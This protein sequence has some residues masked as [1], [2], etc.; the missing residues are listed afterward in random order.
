MLGRFEQHRGAILGNKS[1]KN[2][3]IGVALIDVL[4]DLLLHPFRGFARAGECAAGVRASCNRISTAAAHAHHAFANVFAALCL[5]RLHDRGH[6]RDEKRCGCNHAKPALCRAT[7]WT[8]LFSQR[9]ARRQAARRRPRRPTT[10]P[11]RAS[12]RWP[13]GDSAAARAAYRAP[14]R[15]RR[16]KSISPADLSTRESRA[17]PSLDSALHTLRTNRAAASFGWRPSFPSPGSA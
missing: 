3:L 11:P 7:H 6:R 9:T 12:R 13:R 8:L 17:R 2:R 10:S 5:L 16:T 14:Q 15:F 1:V 4:V